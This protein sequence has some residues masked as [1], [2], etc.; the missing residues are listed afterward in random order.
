[1]SELRDYV[2]FLHHANY[3]LGTVWFDI[4]TGRIELLKPR[5]VPEHNKVTRGELNSRVGRHVGLEKSGFSVRG[6]LMR[7]KDGFYLE[8]DWG[9]EGKGIEGRL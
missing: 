4:T 9:T 3:I 5:A 7:D 1:M 8:I 6:I 2:Y